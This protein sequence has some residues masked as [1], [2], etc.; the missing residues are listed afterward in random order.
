MTLTSKAVEALAKSGGHK[1]GR[2]TDGQGMHLYVRADGQASWILRFRLHERQR[3]M[4]LGVFPA[5]SLKEARDLAYSARLKVREGI[6]PILERQRELQAATVA[7]GL[8]RTFKAATEG[9]IEA[10][11]AT[12]RND[13]HKWQWK[14]TLETHAYPILG[15]MAVSE[16]ETDHVVRVLRPIWPKIPETASRLRGR[17]EAILDYARASGWRKG[18]NPARWKGNL[19]DLL[20]RTSK[21]AKEKH[22]PALPWH[23][24]PAFMEALR[25]RVGMAPDA[26]QFTI[27]T[28]VRSGELRGMVWGE[29]DESTRT[30]II[31]A[32]RMKMKEIHRVPLSDEALAILKR[33]RVGTPKRGD[34]VF[35][36]RDLKAPLSDMAMV[37]LVRGLA[38]D[39]TQE[40][41]LPRWADLEGRV[42]VPHGFRSSFRDWAGET[43][44]EGREVAERA[45]AHV[46]HGVEAAYARSD[47]LE[48][49][50]PLMQ[51]WASFAAGSTSAV[52]LPF[53]PHRLA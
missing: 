25:G 10:R 22:Y 41:D 28:A 4:A 45:L 52:I 8:D 30:W 27:L 11:E 44:S 6:D 15:K 1:P 51:A 33:V 39:G 21:I 26:L 48:R 37:M 17:I 13:K 29:I 31:P 49:R 14:Q 19:A 53:L 50:R 43:R 24:V 9:L 2:H 7:A 12:W 38:T 5:V 35:H 42:V 16:I 40:G 32:E 36:G 47:L 23:R 18:E 3:D 20:P 46:V 34:L